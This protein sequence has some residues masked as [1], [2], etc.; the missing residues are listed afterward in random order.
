M[1]RIAI[2]FLVIGFLL[3]NVYGGVLPAYLEAQ[4]QFF[5]GV[6]PGVSF[7]YD[8][9]LDSN[10]YVGGALIYQPVS[11]VSWIYSEDY[12]LEAH[13]NFHFYTPTEDIPFDMSV[14]LGVVAGKKVGLQGGLIGSYSIKKW[15]FLVNLGY[16]P[17]AGLEAN[18]ELKKNTRL[19]FAIFNASGFIGLK[20]FL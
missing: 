7:G 3:N 10:F 14:Y 6:V 13:G 16:S 1:R 8:H 11:E 5:V 19:F 2:T 20:F 4:R 9:S 15:H 18:Y 12:L 17:R